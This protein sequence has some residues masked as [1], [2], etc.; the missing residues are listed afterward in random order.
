MS[1]KDDP[2]KIRSNRGFSKVAQEET[3]TAKC[4]ENGL[5]MEEQ[6]RLHHLTRDFYRNLQCEEVVF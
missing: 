3:F 2:L 4:R 1:K 6:L 5:D